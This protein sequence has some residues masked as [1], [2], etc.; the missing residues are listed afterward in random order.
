MKDLNAVADM[1]ADAGLTLPLT[2]TVRAGFSDFVASGH[3]DT[4][5]SGLLLHLE[6]MNAAHPE[7]RTTDDRT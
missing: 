5:H 4:D 7:A 2:E 6:A 1:A 3:G